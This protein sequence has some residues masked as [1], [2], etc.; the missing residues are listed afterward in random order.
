VGVKADGSGPSEEVV[1]GLAR[2]VRGKLGSDWTVGESGTA[3]P[4]GGSQPNRTPY[5]PLTR[6]VGLIVEGQ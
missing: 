2:N 3:G 6:D 5:G 1:L 4:T